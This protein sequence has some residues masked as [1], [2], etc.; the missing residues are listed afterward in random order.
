MGD[1]FHVDTQFLRN[2]LN[3]FENPVQFEEAARSGDAAVRAGNVATLIDA[4]DLCNLIILGERVVFDTDV[5]GGRDE[6]LLEQ[7]DRVARRLGDS[8]IGDRLR[9][10]FAGVAPANVNIAQTMQLDAARAATAF[11]PRLARCARNVLD[12]FHLPH[13]PP[14]EPQEHLIRFV[15]SRKRPTPSEIE[16]IA[17]KKQITGRRFYAALLTDETAFRALCDATTR[18]ALTSDVLAVLFMNFRLRLA[19]QRSLAKR[20]FVGTGNLPADGVDSLTYLPSMGRRDFCREFS[21]FV[22]WG[23]DPKTR[24]GHAFDVGL[25]EY[26]LEEWEDGGCQ[27][28]LSERRA[29]PMVVAAVLGSNGLARSRTP[30]TLLEECLRWRREHEPQIAGIRAA[31]REFELLNEAERK[32]KATAFVAEMLRSPS[33][34][35][36]RN[37]AIGERLSVR[38]S[39]LGLG[40]RVVLNPP[41]ALEH[42]VIQSTDKVRQHFE[43]VE[44]REYA[45]ATRLSEAARPLLAGVGADIRQRLIDVFGGTV[46]DAR[47]P[48]YDPDRF[49][50]S[51]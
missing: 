51:A 38:D 48:I 31:T 35:A 41:G 21:R 12:L 15:E 28:Q 17:S 5:G 32:E 42:L 10:S 16:A 45:V 36:A 19:E 13:D 37:R 11:F 14:S 34:E 22:R 50:A 44:S 29:I 9:A 26:V 25:R 23:S 43:K 1:I 47:N 40:I 4:L 49:A 7:I 24:N 6:K 2:A 20:V 18:L 27:L 33:T 46:I 39:W 30:E 8:A 3:V